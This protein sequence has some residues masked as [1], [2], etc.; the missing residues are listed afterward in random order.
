MF[1]MT[2]DIEMIDVS[3]SLVHS[4]SCKIAELNAVNNILE[5][6]SFS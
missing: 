3:V 2:F 6:M 5:N 1:P 4:R